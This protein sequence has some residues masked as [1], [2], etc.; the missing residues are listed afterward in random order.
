[1]WVTKDGMRQWYGTYLGSKRCIFTSAMKILVVMLGCASLWKLMGI[2]K[3]N[4]ILSF[5][6]ASNIF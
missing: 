1:M 6:R 2:S 5:R 4:R 3:T